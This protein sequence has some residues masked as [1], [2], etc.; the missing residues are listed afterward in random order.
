[1]NPEPQPDPFYE[2]GIARPRKAVRQMPTEWHARQEVSA[3]V[4][5]FGQDIGW[6][7]VYRKLGGRTWQVAP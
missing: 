6:R 4:S 1:M 5:K 7:V 3:A 2:W